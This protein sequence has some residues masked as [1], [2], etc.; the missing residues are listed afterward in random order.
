MK[1][2]RFT[3]ALL[4]MLIGFMGCS[5]PA[6]QQMLGPFGQDLEFL[7]KQTEV[8]VLASEFGQ[9]QVAV[10]PAWQGRVMTS[11][12]GGLSGASYGWLNYEL[13][14]SGVLQPHINAFGGEDRFWMGPEGGQY[15]IFF[16]EGAP[17]DLTAWQTPPLIDTESFEV[18]SSEPTSVTFSKKA[19]IR[20]Y[21]GTS[22]DLRIERIVSLMEAPAVESALAIELSPEVEFVAFQSENALFNAGEEVWTKEG[23]LL[24]IWILGMYVPSPQ[25]TIVIPYVDGPEAELG[26]IVNDAYFG[27]VPPERLIVSPE[28]IF[29]KGDGEYRAKIGLSPARAVEVLGSWDSESKTL[30]VVQYNKPAGVS[31]YVNSM[32]E[33][34]EAPYAGDVV[35]S[36]NDGPPEPGAEPLGPFYELE[37]SS[38]AIELVP[39]ESTTHS[40]RTFHFSGSEPAL[41]GIARSVLGVSLSQIENAF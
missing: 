12:S 16:E 32:W 30:T 1:T 20:N 36:Y 22:F 29:F 7:Q 4:G 28:A 8:V 24:S 15:A 35:N 10:V 26:P 14:E 17:F 38:P 27:K 13:I 39:G 23:G 9:A 19:T 5:Q 37:T 34:Q 40:H 3:L 33:V 18:V 11:T 6:E 41:D 25:T 31:D 2:N 21:S